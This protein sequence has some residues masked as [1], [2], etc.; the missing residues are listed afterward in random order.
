[1][2]V[3]IITINDNGN[4]GNRLQNYAV[5]EFLEKYNV[6]VETICNKTKG[7]NSKTKEKIKNII[8]FL[9]PI[10][11]FSRHNAFVKFNKNIKF[12]KYY[13]DLNNIPKNLKEK[14]DFFV[15]GSDQ[16][17]NPNFGRFSDIDVLKFADNNQKISF[18]ASF[19]ISELPERY[20]DYAI[21]NLSTFKSISVREDAGKRIVESLINRKGV[22]VLLDPTMLIE[23]EKWD[24]LLV[25]PKKM[26]E[27]KKYVLNYFLGNLSEERKKKID[28]FAKENNC[29]VINLLDK[30]N[31]FYY[32]GPSE[33]LYLEKNAFLICTDSF[34]SS[35][36]AIL[37]N[38]PFIVFNREDKEENMNSRL[39][40]LINKLNL[41]N[42]E[43]NG[44]I[45]KE[46]LKCD[47][48]EAYSI[49]DDERK[50]AE[51]FVRKSL[52]K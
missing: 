11:K 24:G 19:G 43:Y 4:Y 25:K 49:I 31:E 47:Y 33:F 42:V 20:K 14:Y 41:K 44:K 5:Q 34:H 16:V 52:L 21:N 8:G 23:Q 3:A 40:T 22:D 45:T 30:N 6:E 12:S 37:F 26:K 9:F 15:V 51:D 27:N 10:K 46:N 7:R 13:I 35:V 1:M 38:R 17:W 29:E 48:K 18:S 36:F 50:K 2:K 39:E 32:T 28:K